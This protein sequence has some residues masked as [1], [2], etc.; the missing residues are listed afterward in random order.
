M[1]PETA[2]VLVVAGVCK[3]VALYLQEVTD[4]FPFRRQ[5]RCPDCRC[6][7]CP[8]C[9]AEC[10]EVPRSAFA[11]Y[12]AQASS[13]HILWQN[14]TGRCNPASR[15]PPPLAPVWGAG[16]SVRGRRRGL[17]IANPGTNTFS[18]R[19]VR[20]ALCGI[21]RAV[22]EAS[23]T[24]Q[25][26]LLPSKARAKPSVPGRRQRHLNSGLHRTPEEL[27]AGISDSR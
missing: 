1:R 23:S 15:P 8:D 22:S 19:M 4:Y 3:E 16:N 2:V 5:S 6:P 27:A 25:V 24:G 14:R 20:A 18:C 13:T 26:D 12:Y 17:L 9:K 10:P 11:L 7:A 21:A